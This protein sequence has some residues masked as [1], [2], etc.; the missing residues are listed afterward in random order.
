[1]KLLNP[2][3]SVLFY[4]EGKKWVGCLKK[5]KLTGFRLFMLAF[6][7][8]FVISFL[9]DWL[10]WEIFFVRFFPL[11]LLDFFESFDNSITN[12]ATEINYV[13]IH[14]TVGNSENPK[15]KVEIQTAVIMLL[16]RV[17]SLFFEKYCSVPTKML[18]TIS[19]LLS[20]F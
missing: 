14:R 11:P 3:I 8:D 13:F 18:H 6:E 9:L 2:M 17:V 1:M 7:A 20:I 5:G 12:S 19:Y 15:G 16:L 4:E 10:F